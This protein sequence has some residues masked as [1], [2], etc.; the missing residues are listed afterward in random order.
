MN[1]VLPV[2][3]RSVHLDFHTMP[4]V[5]DVGSEFDGAEFSETLVRSG[6]EAINIFARCN[7]GFA[8]YPTIIGTVHPGLKFDLLGKICES[9]CPRGIQVTA[10]F[11]VRLDHEHAIRHRDWCKVNAEGQIH[12]FRNLGHE[13]REMCLNTPYS[14][15]LLSMIEEV[16]VG[17]PLSGIFLD[18]ISSSP[19]WCTGCLERMPEVGYDPLNPADIGKYARDSVRQFLGRVDD[20]VLIKAPQI[21]RV[22]NGAAYREQRGHVELETLP[23]G[24]S[25][26]DLLPWQARYVRTFKDDVVVMTGRFQEGW[27][28]FGGVLPMQSMLYDCYMAIALNAK[29]SIGDHMHPRG[30]LEPEVY[31]RIRE[32]Y[33][34][35][36][37][38]DPW[39][40][41]S[42]PVTEILIIEPRLREY[43][44]QYFDFESLAGATRMLSEL[45][46]QFD[47]GDGEGEIGQYK[48]IIL[49]DDVELAPALEEKLRLFL[50]NGGKIIG[51]SSSGMSS[52]G[53]ELLLSEGAITFAG[54]E[55]FNTLYVQPTKGFVPDLPNMPISIYE[56]GFSMKAAPECEVLAGLCR[57]Y[58]NLL[59]WDGRHRNMY[60]PPDC[61]ID[62]PGLVRSGGLYQFSFPI[63][64][65]YFKHAMIPYRQLLQGCIVRAIGDPIIRSDAPAHVHICLARANN[66]TIIHMVSYIPELRG[67]KMIVESPAYVPESTLWMRC[68]DGS[69]F[70]AY[71]P[72]KQ[73]LEFSYEKNGICL[74]VPPFCG[75]QMIIL[76]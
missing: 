11:N 35:I 59:S 34:Q 23:G 74:K 57:P 72:T 26:Y 18:C 25:G 31:R 71:I 55:E 68:D 7:V 37:E 14:D 60:T 6:V 51:S 42:E 53:K 54:V 12:D 41:G 75:Y 1:H 19:C 58:F 32:V 47:V 33:D 9:C 64:R 38:L 65:G 52:D 3:R 27:G 40:V 2:P 70:A 44:F 8:Y 22:Y 76:D 17:Y 29:C 43:P 63:F 39:V 16:I 10:Y 46:H 5:S 66:R 67:A 36:V 50:K 24:G 49:P 30:T 20:L 21:R 62:R 69:I 73:N 56:P 45:K 15:H 4:G 61:K 28:D 13:F 48:L